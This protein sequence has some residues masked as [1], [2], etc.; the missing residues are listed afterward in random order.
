MI[1]FIRNTIVNHAVTCTNMDIAWSCIFLHYR[2]RIVP[3]SASRHLSVCVWREAIGRGPYMIEVSKNKTG[4]ILIMPFFPTF[5]ILRNSL[6]K[7]D[8]SETC[9]HP[10]LLIYSFHSSLTVSNI[11]LKP[12]SVPCQQLLNLIVILNPLA[13]K[14]YLF[15]GSTA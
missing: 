14:R 10:T 11:A 4:I 9:D 2:N 3:V 1:I 7:Q 8:I 15:L 5:Y 12:F 6:S 13:C